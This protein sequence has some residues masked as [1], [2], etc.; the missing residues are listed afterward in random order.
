MQLTSTGV[1]ARAI[2]SSVRAPRADD[3]P[4]LLV[5]ASTAPSAGY[6]S[7]AWTGSPG[8]G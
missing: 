5:P 3:G 8:R 7:A 2:R 4:G 1:F 6:R